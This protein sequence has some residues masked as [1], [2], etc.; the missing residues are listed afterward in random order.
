MA[1]SIDNNGNTPN[2]FP[3][4][5]AKVGAIFNRKPMTQKHILHWHLPWTPQLKCSLEKDNTKPQHNHPY[6]DSN[7]HIFDTMGM[8]NYNI[9]RN[10]E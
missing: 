4:L 5:S 3:F 6:P 10:A 9:S 7:F 2:N 8:V 1:D